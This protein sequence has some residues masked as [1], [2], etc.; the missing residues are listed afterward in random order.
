MNRILSRVPSLTSQNSMNTNFKCNICKD[1]GWIQV[2]D[3]T[4]KKCECVKKD[5]IRRQWELYNV[6]PDSVKNLNEYISYDDLTKR[7]KNKAIDYIKNYNNRDKNNWMCLMGQAG[8]GKSHIAIAVG[9]ELMCK[10][11]RV[12]YMPY[13]EAMKEMKGNANNI[14]EYIKITKRYLNADVLLIDDLF[15]DKVKNGRLIS[16]LTEAD[17]KHIYPILNNRY[18]S[19]L[20][21]I[22]S[23]ECSPEILLTLDEALGGRILEKSSNYSSIFQGSKY[24][25]RIKQYV[26]IK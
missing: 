1:T 12:I 13:T 24:N 21:T 6:K 9:A 23:T 11:Y 20:T 4:Y 2:H 18:N 25:Y 15:K 14:E 19:N 3:R 7:A 10:G 5:E 22:I 17:L 16:E 8:S 26:K